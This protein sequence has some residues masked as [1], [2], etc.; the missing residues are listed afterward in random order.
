MR[1]VTVNM[2]NKQLNGIIWLS[3][4]N[5]P[6]PYLTSEGNFCRRAEG[7]SGLHQNDGKETLVSDVRT[8]RKYNYQNILETWHL[9]CKLTPLAPHVL[10][11]M[12]NDNFDADFLVN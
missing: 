2:E 6:N 11:N 8:S 5:R 10:V 7:L 1:G 4:N 3:V 9:Y 12:T